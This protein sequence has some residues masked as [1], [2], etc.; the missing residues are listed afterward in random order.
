MGRLKEWLK[1]VSHSLEGRNPRSRYQHIE[2]HL[3]PVSLAYRWPPVCSVLMQLL[4][5]VGA[6]TCFLL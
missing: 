3:G 5:W 6:I 2:F 1:Q 4:L